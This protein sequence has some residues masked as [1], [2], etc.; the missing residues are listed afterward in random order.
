ML[1]R[2]VRVCVGAWRRA[3]S[4]GVAPDV[5]ATAA[6]RSNRGAAES[7]RLLRLP[8]TLEDA[9]EDAC[10]AEL[11]RVSRKGLGFHDVDAAPTVHE[12][13]AARLDLAYAAARR[14]L[15]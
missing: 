6:A 7:L 14:V 9:L 5:C 10:R 8:D 1:G 15:H 2:R 13:A 12:F 11:R 3:L 4:S